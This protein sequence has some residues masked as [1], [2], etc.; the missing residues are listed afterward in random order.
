VPLLSPKGVGFRSVK[1]LIARMNA[2]RDNERHEL[3]SVD[4]LDVP[5]WQRQI[6]WNDDEM[7][8]LAHSIIN[9]YPIGMMILWQKEDGIRVPIDGRQRLTAIRAFYDGK[10]A[11][12]ALPGVNPSLRNAKFRLLPGDA[13][14]GYHELTFEYRENFE[15]YELSLVQY[16]NIAEELAMDIFVMLQGGKSLTKTEVRAGQV[17]LFL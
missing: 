1:R 5:P 10:V 11:V 12:P 14:R 13:D 16:E 7:G 17:Q 9:N 15:D 4:D 2:N 6:V 3:I 8:L